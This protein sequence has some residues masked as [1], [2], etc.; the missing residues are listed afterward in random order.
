MIRKWCL[1]F[2]KSNKIDWLDINS[3]LSDHQKEISSHLQAKE[4]QEMR[5]MA[6]NSLEIKTEYWRQRAKSRWD[7]LGDRTS[8]FFYK[9]VK[10]RS[11][12]NEIKAIKNSEGTWTTDQPQ[13]KRMFLES[14]I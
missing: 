1:S 4:D 5:M 8:A 13:I 12:R 7:D 3:N 14:F 9:S 11:F 10:G 6:L 2:K